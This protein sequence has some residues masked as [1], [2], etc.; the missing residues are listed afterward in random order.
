MNFS[1][2]PKSCGEQ[3]RL[4]VARVECEDLCDEGGGGGKAGRQLHGARGVSLKLWASKSRLAT[5][6]R[7][8]DLEV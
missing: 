2:A 4:C 5:A 1:F 8:C 6:L 7:D 3:Y